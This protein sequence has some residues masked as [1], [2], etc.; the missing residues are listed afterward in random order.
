MGNGVKQGGVLSPLL[1]NLCID[2]LLIRLKKSGVGCH[3]NN[4]YMGALSY[5]D[6]ITISCPSLYG[7]SIV[8]D[9]CNYFAHE[10]F[11]TFNTKK[12]VCIKFGELIKPQEFAKLDGQLLKWQTNVR[13]LGNYLNNTL[14][15]NIKYSHFIGKFNNLKSKFGFI[16][17]DIFSN[18]FKSYCC[19]FC[20]SFLW[21]FSSNGFNK[22]CTQWNKSVRNI[23]YLPHNAYRW[24]LGA[25]LNQPHIS[26]QFYIIDIKFLHC[27]LHCNNSIVN[28]CIRHASHDA[29]TII[30]YK[31]PF[32][33][34]NLFI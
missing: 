9:R 18:L 12:T 20:G 5:A 13:H 7:L 6:D 3:M 32:L 1:F 2:G 8:L 4:I 33:D 14:D 21:K 23:F 24:L 17:P 16:Q 25:L 34:I 10:H 19:L 11:I 22:C 29:N 30:G 31:L 28:Q 15:S 26:H 27:M